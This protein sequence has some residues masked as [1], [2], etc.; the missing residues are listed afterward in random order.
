MIDTVAAVTLL[1]TTLS[2]YQT[3][4]ILIGTLGLFTI[5]LERL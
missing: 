4:A 3:V 2:S 1:T 5:T